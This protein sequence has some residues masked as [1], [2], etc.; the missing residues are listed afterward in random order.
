MEGDNKRLTREVEL[1]REM[2]VRT[3][4]ATSWDTI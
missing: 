4:L 2:E 1:K 3:V